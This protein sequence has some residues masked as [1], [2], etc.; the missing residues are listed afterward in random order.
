PP[1]TAR[2]TSSSVIAVAGRASRAPPPAPNR[3]VVKPAR[4]RRHSSR[5]ITAGFVFTLA[6][7]RSEVTGS[8]PLVASMVS[9]WTAT[10][11]RLLIVISTPAVCNQGGHIPGERRGVPRG[12]PEAV[13]SAFPEA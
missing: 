1:S 12:V 8:P 3:D 4:E 6:A 9:T 7:R 10:A 5:R 11:N 13:S 2:Y